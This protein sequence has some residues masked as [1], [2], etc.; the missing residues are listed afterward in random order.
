MITQNNLLVKLIT[1]MKEKINFKKTSF[2]IFFLA[3]KKNRIFSKMV[4][5]LLII[6]TLQITLY[7]T[8]HLKNDLFIFI[9]NEK[10]FAFL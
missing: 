7:F 5:A 3:I 4:Y 8:L 1:N 2:L 9:N 6:T 10:N